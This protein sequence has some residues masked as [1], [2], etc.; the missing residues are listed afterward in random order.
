ML[1]VQQPVGDSTVLEE[2]VPHCHL[3]RLQLYSDSRNLLPILSGAKDSSTITDLA[4]RGEPTQVR[5][6]RTGS[7]TANLAVNNI[8]TKMCR[9]IMRLVR[10]LYIRR[11]VLLAEVGEPNGGDCAEG[12]DVSALLVGTYKFPR[13]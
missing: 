11:P 9:R 4:V 7:F 3:K 6:V 5:H 1:C 8:R 2:K 13:Q 12:D 10:D